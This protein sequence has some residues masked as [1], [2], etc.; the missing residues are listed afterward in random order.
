MDFGFGVDDGG[1]VRDGAG[2]VA[3]LGFCGFNGGGRGTEE[4]N[5]CIKASIGDR[6]SRDN[7][8]G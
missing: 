5:G 3:T 8:G 2:V 1:Y 7:D 6:G 4:G